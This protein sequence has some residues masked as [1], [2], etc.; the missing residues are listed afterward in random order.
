MRAIAERGIWWDERPAGRYTHHRATDTPGRSVKLLCEGW[1]TVMT[2][3][4]FLETR[5]A[6]QSYIT[7]STVGLLDRSGPTVSSLGSST[8]IKFGDVTGLL[9]CAH[10]VHEIQRRADHGLKEIGLAIFPTAEDSKQNATIPIEA[11]NLLR[12]GDQPYTSTGPDIGFIVLPPSFAASFD[13]RA[14]VVDGHL[15]ATRSRTAQ[16]EMACV[17]IV[18]GVV[19]KW[20]KEHTPEPDITRVR[21]IGATGKVLCQHD[22]EGFDTIEFAVEQDQKIALPE[23]YQGVSGGGIWRLFYEIDHLGQIDVKE[24][25]LL[26]VAF[27]ES[28][29]TPGLIIGHGP[30]TIY[31]HLPEKLL[32]I[33]AGRQ[34]G[35]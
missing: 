1:G 15:Q 14:S 13:A 3:P 20:I 24:R 33:T 17:E 4:V 25:R 9:T 30:T 19:A 26:G 2:A 5:D 31:R 18:A 8:Y 10:A 28:Y 21:G 35:T 7:H 34:R 12:I 6:A 22:K 32:G 23:T 11:L 16:P 29:E 27:Y